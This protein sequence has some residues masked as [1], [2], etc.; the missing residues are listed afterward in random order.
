MMN[1]ELKTRIMRR[2]YAIWFV[3]RGLPMVA[4]SAASFY[5]AL[6]VTAERFFVAQIASNFIVA[7]HSGFLG[8]TSFIVSAL[9]SVEPS[10]L[11]L[12]SMAGIISFGLTVKLLRSIRSIVAGAGI[13]AAEAKRF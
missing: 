7:A 2:I 3:R 9:N 1:N 6:R 4:G 5:L 13:T 10:I 12:I 8:I 11:I